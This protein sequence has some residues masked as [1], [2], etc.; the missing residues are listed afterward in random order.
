M[1]GKDW[2]T[3]LSYRLSMGVAAITFIVS[4]MDLLYPPIF[5]NETASIKAQVIGQDVVNLLLGVPA[6]LVAMNASRGGSMKA[7]TVW[8]GLLAYFAY[9][10]LSYATLFKLNQ[11]FLAYTAAFALSL[12]A[13][14]L[15]LAGM[16]T[17]GL[18]VDASLSVRRWT[19]YSMLLILAIIALLWTPDVAGYYNAGTIPQ[20]LTVDGAHTL[21]IVFQ[22][23]SILL[24]LALIVAWLTRR[25]DEMG[26][27]LAPVILVKALS[28][29]LAVLGMIAAMRYM[30]TPADLGQAAVFVAG[31]ALIGAYTRQ[32]FSGIEI[33]DSS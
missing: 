21:I 16:N 8:L 28:I 13:T 9:T 27:I 19:P 10:F 2:K 30:G 1:K 33:R 15:N 4:L 7:R 26:Y 23:Y 14:L 25:G 18:Q 22:D 6:L 17:D 29:A 12:Y 31:A 3:D 5:L 24:P 20:A 11:G 32:Y